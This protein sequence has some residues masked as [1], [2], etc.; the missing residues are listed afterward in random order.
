MYFYGNAE[1]ADGVWLTPLVELRNLGA[2]E[3]RPVDSNL[4][5][6]LQDQSGR[7]I[8]YNIFNLSAVMA[9]SWQYQVG[10]HYDPIKPGVV[11]GTSFPFDVPPDLGDVWLRAKQNPD[12]A[13]YLGNVSQ[14]PETQ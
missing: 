12:F 14:L 6:Y 11:I 3:I 4:S 10:A 13:V 5:L 7:I 1:I 9:A 2:A 8:E